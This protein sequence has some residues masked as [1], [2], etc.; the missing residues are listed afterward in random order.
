MK[1][2]CIWRKNSNRK[3]LKIACQSKKIGQ[4]VENPLSHTILLHNT[5]CYYYLKSLTR[6]F[7]PLGR[8]SNKVMSE[9]VLTRCG[10][11]QYIQLPSGRKSYAHAILFY[12]GSVTRDFRPHGS[13]SS[14]VML[15]VELVR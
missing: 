15:A 14:K 5:Q 8:S 4:V 10:K 9:V 1:N 2:Q 13:P 3:R 7:R 12:Q 11:M 6:D